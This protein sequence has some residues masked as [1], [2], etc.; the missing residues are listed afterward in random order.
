MAFALPFSSSQ[1]SASQV[2]RIVGL[3][4][5]IWPRVGVSP[6]TCLEEKSVSR[7]QDDLPCIYLNIL[8]QLRCHRLQG[9]TFFYV[10]SQVTSLVRR[11]IHPDF[12]DFINFV[13]YPFILV[14]AGL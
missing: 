10:C 2:A 9:G 7:T 4:H 11:G 3:S 8:S 6:V 14:V 13:I 1:T 5:H 12:K